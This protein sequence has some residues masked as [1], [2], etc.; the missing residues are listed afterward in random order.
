MHIFLNHSKWQKLVRMKR[1]FVNFIIP[2]QQDNGQWAV[3]NTILLSIYLSIYLSRIQIMMAWKWEG[4]YKR[5]YS[6]DLKI[7]SVSKLFNDWTHS[8]MMKAASFRNSIYWFKLCDIYSKYICI[9]TY[10]I[11]DIEAKCEISYNFQKVS[12]PTHLIWVRIHVL[13]IF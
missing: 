11:L 4:E 7:Y 5:V 3:K 13:D 12:V 8:N 9:N 2:S 10:F 1:R 6:A